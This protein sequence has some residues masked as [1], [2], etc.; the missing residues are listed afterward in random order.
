[1]VVSEKSSTNTW[2]PYV[3]NRKLLVFDPQLLVLALEV[4]VLLT[5]LVDLSFNCLQFA[6]VWHL[7]FLHH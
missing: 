4:K 3:I 2:Q 6:L 1:M 5:I 7:Q